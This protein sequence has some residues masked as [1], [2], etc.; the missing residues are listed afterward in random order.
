MKPT[1]HHAGIEG[2]ILENLLWIQGS[3]LENLNL[4]IGLEQLELEIIRQHSRIPFEE[5]ALFTLL[6]DCRLERFPPRQFS[7]VERL[8]AKVEPLLTLVRVEKHQHVYQKQGCC[9]FWGGNLI[10][11]FLVPIPEHSWC[12]KRTALQRCLAHKK[13]PPPTRTTVGPYA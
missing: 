2:S 7:R 10:V 12:D 3:F 9:R 8:K 5:Y 6:L 13:L 4:R 11:N 1:P